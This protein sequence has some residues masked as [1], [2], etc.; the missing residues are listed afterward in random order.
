MYLLTGAAGMYFFDPI[1]G[2]R[3]RAAAR[4]KLRARAAARSTGG[5]R[6][7]HSGGTNGDAD[8]MAQPRLGERSYAAS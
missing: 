7:R 6:P 3:R 5:Q 2:H 4:E 1:S 8:A